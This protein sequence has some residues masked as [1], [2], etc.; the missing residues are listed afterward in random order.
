MKCHIFYVSYLQTE[1]FSKISVCPY[2]LA[3]HL[4]NVALTCAGY[5]G[6]GVR[7]YVHGLMSHTS[8]N[9]EVQL[10]H[11]SIKLQCKIYL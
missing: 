6:N 3:L 7:S 8:A 11:T 9:Q 1:S 10:K 2:V 5:P 4:K